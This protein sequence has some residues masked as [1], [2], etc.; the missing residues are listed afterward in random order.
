MLNVGESRGLDVTDAES[1][2]IFCGLFDS[3]ASMKKL[4]DT[5]FLLAVVVIGLLFT[6]CN[7]IGG[8][9]SL[10]MSGDEVLDDVSLT[11]LVIGV[12]LYGQIVCWE[13]TQQVVCYLFGQYGRMQ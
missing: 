8:T 12:H 3:N 10:D 1:D 9:C 5:P 2:W 13:K 11:E 7:V 6:D 4:D